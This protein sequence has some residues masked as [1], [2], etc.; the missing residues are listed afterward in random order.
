MVVARL[1]STHVL[2]ASKM[3]YGDENVSMKNE[4]LSFPVGGVWCLRTGSQDS[5]EGED[6]RQMACQR[7]VWE[8]V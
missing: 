8:R 5:G 4:L 3:V 7:E 6:C 2:A 1:I